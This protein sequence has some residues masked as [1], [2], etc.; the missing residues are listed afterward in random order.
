M[1][2]YEIIVH[3]TRDLPCASAEEAAAIVRRQVLAATGAT[4][5]LLHFAVWRKD[6]AAAASPLPLPVRQTL[7]DFFTALERCAAEAEITFRERV[8]AILIGAPADGAPGDERDPAEAP[9]RVWRP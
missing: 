6:P 4:D 5:A 2:H 8:A 9:P 3:V 1:P 7:H